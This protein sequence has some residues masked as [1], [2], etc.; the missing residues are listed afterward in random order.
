M[1]IWKDLFDLL[2]NKLSEH[3]ACVFP[4]SVYEYYLVCSLKPLVD[5]TFVSSFIAMSPQP[6]IDLIK[7]GGLTPIS[8]DHLS[9]WFCGPPRCASNL[10]LVS[11]KCQC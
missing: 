10:S 11:L 6:Q 1:N 9:S 2:T 3:C 5:F 7:I 8:L 4:P